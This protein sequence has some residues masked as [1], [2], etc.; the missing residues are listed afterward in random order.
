MKVSICIPCYE[1]GGFGHTFLED[2]LYSIFSQTYNNYEIVVSDNS[3]DEKIEKVCNKYSEEGKVIK[4][5]KNEGNRRSASVNINN[6]I[7]NSSGDLIKILFQ[8][9]LFYSKTSLEETVEPFTKNPS[10][11]WLASSCCHTKNG[12]DFI[13]YRDPKY[14]EDIINGN[15]QIGSPSVITLRNNVD[16]P[17][18]DPDFNWLMDCDYYQRMEIHY[19]KPY[20]LNKCTVTIRLWEGQMTK[21]IPEGLKKLECE[22]ILKKYSHL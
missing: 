1:M 16:L 3:E 19:G 13:N 10:L 2:N 5:L 6:C 4:Y 9:D 11:I 18:F 7:N 22:K 15:N 20:L 17:R 12:Y 8:D 14:T 21:V